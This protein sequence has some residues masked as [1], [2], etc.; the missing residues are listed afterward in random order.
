MSHDIKTIFGP[1]KVVDKWV[2][3]LKSGEFKQK[4]MTLRG[5]VSDGSR[6]YCC[7]GV[8]IENQLPDHESLYACTVPP[9]DVLD[10]INIRFIGFRSKGKRELAL[11]KANNTWPAVWYNNEWVAV[12]ELNDGSSRPLK[13]KNLD[14]NEIAALIQNHIQYTD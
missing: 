6:G 12:T 14:F 5:I 11:D 13:G 7:L 8:L 10:Q 1:R 2:E 4:K 9:T 3:S